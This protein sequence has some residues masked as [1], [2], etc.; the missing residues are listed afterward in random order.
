LIINQYSSNEEIK[1]PFEFRNPVGNSL[2]ANK[3]FKEIFGVK[4]EQKRNFK[5][6][7]MRVIDEETL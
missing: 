1:E 6:K 2:S 5:T 3:S 4:R 7:N